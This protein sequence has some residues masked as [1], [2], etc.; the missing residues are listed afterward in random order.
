MDKLF[1]QILNMSFTASVVIL[2]VILIRLVLKKAPKVFIYALWAAVLFRLL[3]PFSLESAMALLPTSQPIPQDIIYQTVPQIDS[4]FT[5]VD[6]VVNPVLPPVTNHTTSINPIQIWLAIGQY[7]W[8]AGMIAM[9]VYSMVSYGKLRKRLV[10]AVQLR[11]NI[12]LV[13][14]LD[15]PFVTGLIS[16]KIYL[17]S[18]LEA[19]E[20][21]YIIAHEQCHIRRFDHVTRLLGFIAL[22]LHWFNPLVWIA[23]VLSGKDMELSCD[24]A[25][26]KAMNGD[27]RT[28][29]AQSLL[30]LAT[31]RKA[32]KLLTATPLAFGEGETKG[33]VKNVLSYKKPALWVMVLCLVAVALILVS[34]GSNPEE[35]E[36]FTSVAGVGTELRLE[37]TA[38]V[39][40]EIQEKTNY[41]I[42]CMVTDVLT[43]TEFP[44]GAKLNF[45]CDETL[46]MTT[47]DGGTFVYDWDEPNMNDSDLAVGDIIRVGYTVYDPYQDGNNYY[48]HL[49]ADSIFYWGLDGIPT[50]DTQYEEV[51]DV[52]AYEQYEAILTQELDTAAYAS[53]GDFTGYEVT[54]FVYA[55]DYENTADNS[56]VQVYDLEFALLTDDPFSV[57]WTGGMYM[58]EQGRVQGIN[59]T[60]GLAVKYVDS[61]LVAAVFL[62]RDAQWV[63]TTEDN[64]ETAIDVVNSALLGTL[65]SDEETTITMT[66]EGDAEEISAIATHKEGYSIAIPVDEWA[67]TDDN[68]WQAIANEDVYFDIFYLDIEDIQEVATWCLDTQ[69]EVTD[70][71][72]RDT[73]F[74]SNAGN[75][76]FLT[77][78]GASE[79]GY[80]YGLGHCPDE[81]MEGF[82]TR[83]GYI[84][85]TVTLW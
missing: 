54:R 12:Y 68:H 21:T 83:I 53:L 81:A 61:Q 52:V 64:R 84:F 42:R 3:C 71:M 36:T 49:E 67:E 40:L 41:A 19:A 39:E 7:L 78:L 26:M 28:D 15:T 50:Y 82:G 33:R 14:Y 48:N 79:N 18:S 69:G 55:W 13:D 27:I 6:S 23:F 73:I 1:L 2:A 62:P 31:G 46:T 17:P 72:G 70:W 20:Q 45:T 57:T 30:R 16:P 4:G 5:V 66:I 56:T 35:E 22:T 60:S 51:V 77:A 43:N 63:Y 58:D 80:Y 11:D 74:V 59:G 34:L 47:K 38:Y 37:E 25:V 44:L 65:Y 29:Y 75:T 24:E 8:I 32:S 9:A 10:G 85:D 76:H